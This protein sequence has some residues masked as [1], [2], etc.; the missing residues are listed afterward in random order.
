MMSNDL[1]EKFKQL[2]DDEM[3]RQEKEG[4][5]ISREEAIKIVEKEINDKE[6][7]KLWDWWVA[8]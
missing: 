4:C 5:K 8:G 7:R 6:E 3:A 1:Q 2:I